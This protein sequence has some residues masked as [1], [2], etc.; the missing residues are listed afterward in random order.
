MIAQL[1]YTEHTN[2]IKYGDRNFPATLRQPG[3]K[4]RVVRNQSQTRIDPGLSHW[5]ATSS[6][7]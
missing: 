1:R 6:F 7:G 2:K 3:L 4:T 5:E